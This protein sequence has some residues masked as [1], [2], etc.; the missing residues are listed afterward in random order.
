MKNK[1]LMKKSTRHWK[2]EKKM[3]IQPEIMDLISYANF[4]TFRN[5]YIKQILLLQLMPADELQFE[6][7][8]K[9]K[10]IKVK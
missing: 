2:E 9:R 1:T 6:I 8:S 10:E 4:L 5:D 7:S 3:E